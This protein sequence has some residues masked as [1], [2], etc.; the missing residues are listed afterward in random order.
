[1]SLEKLKTAK[2]VSEILQI[3]LQRVYELTRRKLLPSVK[4][5]DRQYRY[6]ETALLNWITQGGN[7][8]SEACSE[9]EK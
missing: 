9:D 2:E 5:G 7:R 6:S 4:L 8:E 3:D 1:M